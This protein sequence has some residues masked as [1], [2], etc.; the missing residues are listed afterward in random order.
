MQ[1]LI[2]CRQK[3]TRENAPTRNDHLRDHI[4][5]LVNI[6]LWA[7]NNLTRNGGYYGA[8]DNFAHVCSTYIIY[9]RAVCYG[10]IIYEMVV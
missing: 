5:D 10:A 3:P 9:V 2:I 7:M 1:L 8:V 4:N 6:M